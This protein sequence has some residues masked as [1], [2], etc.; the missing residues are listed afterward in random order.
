MSNTL[1]IDLGASCIKAIYQLD[2]QPNPCAVT[3]LPNL[4]EVDGKSLETYRA[5]STSPNIAW[6]SNKARPEKVMVVDELA[7]NYFI[8]ENYQKLKIEEGWYRI[9]ATIGKILS[10]ED[11]FPV[12]EPIPLKL[13]ILLPFGEFNEDTIKEF[14]KDLKKKLAKF[15]YKGSKVAIAVEAIQFYPE[16]LGSLYLDKQSIRDNKRQ[17]IVMLGHRNCSYLVFEG[18]NF[19]KGNSTQLGFHTLVRDFCL[20]TPAQEEKPKTT[21]ILWS[22]SQNPKALRRLCK[23]QNPNLQETE[24]T[25]LK[26]AFEGSCKDIWQ[27]IKDWLLKEISD[28]DFDCLK[29]SGGVAEFFKC[30]IEN[31]PMFSKDVELIGCKYKEVIQKAVNQPGQPLDDITAIRLLDCY[32]V[33]SV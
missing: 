17:I 28:V 20:K 30:Y 2:S 5:L 27:N 11:I 24:L 13:S 21:A 14:T 6:L 29:I 10:I 16:G 25:T 15:Y 31:E 8:C 19:I 1:C 23:S 7:Q 4:V 32:G 9:A 3:L 33:S 22:S 26:S 18:T 12:D